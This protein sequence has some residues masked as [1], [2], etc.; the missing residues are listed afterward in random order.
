M[1]VRMIVANSHQDTRPRPEHQRNTRPPEKG[2]TRATRGSA[3]ENAES[4]TSGQLDT[5]E[6][7]LEDLYP[8]GISATQLNDIFRFDFDQIQEWLGIEPEE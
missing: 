4:L 3:K 7:I 6:S 5:V 8:E 2:G 1:R